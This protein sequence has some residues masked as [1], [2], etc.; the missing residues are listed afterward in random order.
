MSYILSGSRSIDISPGTQR[1]FPLVL[2]GRS[3]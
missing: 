3:Y 1:N 2:W